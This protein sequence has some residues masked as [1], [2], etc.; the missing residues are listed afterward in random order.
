V[1][2][3]TTLAL[4][5]TALSYI[6]P[7]VSLEAATVKINSFIVDDAMESAQVLTHSLT[8]SLTHLTTY[9]LTHRPFP[10][11]YWCRPCTTYNIK[12][13]NLRDR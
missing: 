1:D 4:A 8:Y 10:N 11:E 12:L 3:D 9:S 2:N 5:V 13:Q 7:F 6:P